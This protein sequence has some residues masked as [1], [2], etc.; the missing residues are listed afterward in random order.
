MT[1]SQAGDIC[2]LLYDQGVLE[3]DDG[4]AGLMSGATSAYSFIYDK[5]YNMVIT[6]DML[7]L[8]PCSGSVVVTDPNTGEVKAM[9]SYPSYDTNRISNSV[10][11]NSLLANE[12]RPLYNRA[13]LRGNGAGIHS[14]WLLPQ[15]L[16]KKELLTQK[17]LSWIIQPLQKLSH[18]LP[19][20][21]K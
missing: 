19:V 6:P 14:K 18:R 16:L 10:Y 12:S 17:Q 3:E 1:R 4:Y 13:S 21:Q 11:F 15:R 9:V 20:G 5:I 8:D 7:G 2:L